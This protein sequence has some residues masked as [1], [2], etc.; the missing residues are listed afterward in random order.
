MAASPST[1]SSSPSRPGNAAGLSPRLHHRRLR[2]FDGTDLAVQQAGTSGPLLALANG[3]G[4]SMVA[5]TPLLAHFAPSYRLRSW[6]YR[7]LYRSGPPPDPAAVRIEDHVRDLRLVVDRHGP[8][9]VIGWSMGV[10]VAVQY[11]LEYPDAVLGL[12]LVCG[13]PGDPFAG[14]LR[15]SHSRWAVPAFCR[16]VQAVPALFGASIRAATSFPLAPDL[17]LRSRV[18]APSCDM[19]VFR[20]LATEFSKLDWRVYARTTRAMGYHDAWSRLS[21]ITVPTLAIGG[22]RDLFTPTEVATATARAIPKGEAFVIDGASHYAPVEFPEVI[23]ERIERFLDERV[24]GPRLA[25]DSAS[26]QESA[27]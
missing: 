11:A 22:T 16:V 2:A 9:V 15:T 26:A 24:F 1:R 4:G 13:A 19:E 18:V 27:S 20:M 12:V 23:N 14:V 8:A 6:D 25:G 3:L 5:W 21:E 17:L 7:G 10:Q